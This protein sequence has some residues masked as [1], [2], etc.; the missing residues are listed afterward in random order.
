MKKKTTCA[1][2]LIIIIKLKSEVFQLLGLNF[3]LP[4]L[5]VKN[6]TVQTDLDRLTK[7]AKSCLFFYINIMS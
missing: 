2:I 1:K 6:V 4:F 5:E 3:R 7:T